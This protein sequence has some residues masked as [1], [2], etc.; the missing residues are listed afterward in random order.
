[1]TA[2]AERERELHTQRAALAEE[3]RELARKDKQQLQVCR[4]GCNRSRILC[5]PLSPDDQF[6]ITLCDVLV[7]LMNRAG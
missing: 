5:Q 2:E 3:G 4:K 6:G 7:V 1:M